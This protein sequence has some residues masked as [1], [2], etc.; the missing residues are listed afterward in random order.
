MTATERLKE[1]ERLFQ[2]SQSYNP[3]QF[4]S[5]F[6]KA[7][8]EATNYNQDLI[9]ER[10]DAIGQAQAL[11]AELRAHYAKS[12]IRNPLEQEAL[13]AQRRSG[14]TSDITRLTD[15]LGQRQSRYQDVLGK[16]LQAYLGDMQRHESE[17]ENAWRLYQDALAQEEAARARAQQ[18]AY[19][20]ALIRANTPVDE[21]VDT[22]DDLV[23]DTEENNWTEK[24]SSSTNPKV[25]ILNALPM[26]L[27]NYIGNQMVPKP[28]PTGRPLNWWEKITNTLS[29]VLGGGGGKAW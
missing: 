17:R 15:L 20:D 22:V 26:A 4:Q 8:G 19:I 24:L 21:T 1:Y 25:N 5:D 13:I 10:A 3:A 12:A 7:Y 11:P 2:E 29:P 23:I 6:E 27:G 18:Q 16:H 9:S 28:T 14:I